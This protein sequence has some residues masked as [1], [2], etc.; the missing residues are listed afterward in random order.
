[1]ESH[2]E[3]RLWEEILCFSED[4]LKLP[5]NAIKVT[6]L[7]ETILA[8]F[9]MDEIL[10][11]LKNHIVGMNCGRWDYI[12]SYIKKLRNHPQF[13]VPDRAKITMKEHFLNSYSLLLIQTCHKRGAM[14][15]GGMSAF[16][17]IKSDEAKNQMALTQA[18]L[19]KEREA[20]NGHD[21][22]W[23]AHPGLVPLA[24][25]VFD[26]IMPKA[27]QME[28][29]LEKVTITEEDLLKPP[30]G[31]I[32]EQGLRDNV[33]IGL[34]YIESWLRGIGCVPIRNLME[35]AATA[36]ISRA[37]IWQWIHN[38]LG[39]LKEGAKVTYSL[40]EKILTEEKAK[41]E[42]EIQEEMGSQGL[43]KRKF[44][45]ASQLFLQSAKAEDF[46]EFLTLPAYESLDQKI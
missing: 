45:Q 3:A 36:E 40:V 7:I 41:I 5:Q 35:D 43:Q 19:D 23:V 21:G 14:A 46:I 13:L 18:R 29:L 27:N 8:A 28:K 20:T 26:K 30:V 16:I 44:E 9:E 15:I 25:E 11:E 38:P 10:Y 22:T 32:T 34:Q 1:M 42:Q 12:F 4:F 33:S 2:L 6:V 39:K 31:E 37:Q 17:P 24:L